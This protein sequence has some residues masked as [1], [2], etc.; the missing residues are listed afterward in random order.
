[1][2]ASIGLFLLFLSLLSWAQR[3]VPTNLTSPESRQVLEAFLGNRENGYLSPRPEK[4]ILITLRNALAPKEYIR[5]IHR[6]DTL[7]SDTLR[8]SSKEQRSV[9]RF[10][11]QLAKH[12]WTRESIAQNG[13]GYFELDERPEPREPEYTKSMNWVMPPFFIRP[14]TCFVYYEYYCGAL[15][16][17]GSMEIYTKQNGQWKNW[18]IL[19]MFAS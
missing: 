11:H 12:T 4:H 6:N 1:M 10:L 7:Y 9:K 18:R 17:G 13:I 2:R 15:C 8:L 19:F 16:A 3:K 14:D 5:N